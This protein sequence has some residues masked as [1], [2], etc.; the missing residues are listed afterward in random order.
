MDTIKNPQRV[1]LIILL[2]LLTIM[3][4]FFFIISIVSKELIFIVVSILLFLT[5]VV[6]LGSIIVFLINTLI[7]VDDNSIRITRFSKTVKEIKKDDVYAIVY[8]AIHKPKHIAET[9]LFVIPKPTNGD[10]K[11]QFYSLDLRKLNSYNYSF[12]RVADSRKVICV[13]VRKKEIMDIFKK[14]NYSIT[15]CNDYKK[16]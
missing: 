12:N 14:H 8:G 16:Q 10:E 3:F 13:P 6:G 7:V 5:H 4:S 11:E 1:Y 9:T 2:V 15:F